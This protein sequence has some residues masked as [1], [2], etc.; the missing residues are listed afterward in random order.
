MSANEALFQ[1]SLPTLQTISCAFA[2]KGTCTSSLYHPVTQVVTNMTVILPDVIC[3]LQVD[4][5]I[6]Y[7]QAYKTAGFKINRNIEGI[8]TDAMIAA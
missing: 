7:K 2:V 8:L 4:M 6:C 1:L 5:H 3:M